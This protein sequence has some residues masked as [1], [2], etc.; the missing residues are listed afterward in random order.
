MTNT[1]YIP[2]SFLLPPAPI[3]LPSYPKF[4]DYAG[5]E[6]LVVGIQENLVRPPLLPINLDEDGR[7]GTSFLQIGCPDPQGPREFCKDMSSC[8]IK[9]SR[10]K[11]FYVTSGGREASQRCLGLKHR[12]CTGVAH[13]QKPILTG[14]NIREPRIL[15][16]LKKGTS[17]ILLMAKAYSVF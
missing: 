17:M 8:P 15:C 11:S 5:F 7:I 1:S 3:T 2:S 12:P 9:T 16:C 10:V 14:A 4:L 6:P 13:S